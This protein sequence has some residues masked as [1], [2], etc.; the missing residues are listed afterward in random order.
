MDIEK[1][2]ELYAG[3]ITFWGEIDRQYILPFGTVEDVKKAVKREGKPSST[4]GLD[5][6]NKL[7]LKKLR[8]W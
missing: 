5:I 2:E 6:N 7:N 8:R 4:D 3:K 1:P